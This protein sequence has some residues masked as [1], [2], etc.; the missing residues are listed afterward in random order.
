MVKGIS[1]QV[2]VVQGPEPK[3][4]E[5]AI[6]ILKDEAVSRGVTDEE[7]MKQAQQAIQERDMA[8]RRRHLYGYGAFWAAGGALLMGLVW[9]A[10]V[11]W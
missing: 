11:L 3:L 1:R 6:F 9:L 10:T 7:L 8:G 2:I 4:F 5:Q